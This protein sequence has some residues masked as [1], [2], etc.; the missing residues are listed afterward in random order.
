MVERK[1]NE[2]ITMKYIIIGLQ[3]LNVSN[4]ITMK[5]IIIGLHW[6]NVK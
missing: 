6:L 2:T 5:Y 3:W 4:E 1:C